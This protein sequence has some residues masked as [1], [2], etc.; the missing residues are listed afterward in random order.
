MV[1]D[2]AQDLYPWVN[3]NELWTAFSVHA[4]KKTVPMLFAWADLCGRVASGNAEYS[5]EKEAWLASVEAEALYK[6]PKAK[7]RR[8]AA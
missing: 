3:I 7:R 8:R 2:S 4:P 1:R 6:A 5:L